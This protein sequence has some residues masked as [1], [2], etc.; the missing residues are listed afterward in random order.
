MSPIPPNLKLYHIL[1]VDRLASV[2]EDGCLFSD[3]EATKRNSQG[4]A[5]GMGHIKRRRLEVCRLRTAPRLHVGDCV[6]FYFCPRSVMLFIFWRNVHPD[7]TYHGGQENILHLEFDMNKVR[8]WAE[9][10]KL[11]WAFTDSNASSGWFTDYHDL[12]NLDKLRWDIIAS[13]QWTGMTD[14]H[15]TQAFKQAEFLVE[16]IGAID[17]ERVEAVRDILSSHSAEGLPLVRRGW[18]Y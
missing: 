16:T 15:A 8:E 4:S 17:E 6:P 9:S 18:Y 13:G 12:A 10:E 14:G 3:A 5:I 2:L 1:H 7:L 11:H